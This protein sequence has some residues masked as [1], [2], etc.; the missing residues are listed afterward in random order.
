MAACREDFLCGDY[1][2]VV[3]V[4]F[5]SYHYGANASEAVERITTHGKFFPCALYFVSSQHIKKNRKV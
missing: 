3:L 5:R 4:I 2:D 1:F